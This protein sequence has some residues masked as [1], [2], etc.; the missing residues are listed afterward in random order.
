M[1]NNFIRFEAV[2]LKVYQTKLMAVSLEFE[3]SD[4]K[5]SFTHYLT[6][7]QYKQPSK[8]EGEKKKCN[9][10]YFTLKKE[11]V[12]TTFIQ[13][14]KVQE[15][16]SE[17]RTPRQI[18]CQLRE[19]NVGKIITGET[20]KLAGLIKTESSEYEKDKKT[21]GIFV[22]FVLINSLTQKMNIHGSGYD[23]GIIN[24]M[25]NNPNIFYSLIKSFCPTIYGH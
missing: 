6:D 5:G 16:D 12:K 19:N 23:L 4:C 18:M 20:I 24:E 14:L 22:P 13:R 3:C 21:Q 2:V 1:I 25:K 8:C 11:K 15:I 9:G 17:D 7:G 10:K